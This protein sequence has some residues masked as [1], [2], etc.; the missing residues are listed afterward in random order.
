[1]INLRFLSF[2]LCLAVVAPEML[3]AADDPALKPVATVNGEAIT[4]RQ[5]EDAMLA[6]EGV[7][8]L[9]QTITSIIEQ[10]D[11]TRLKDDDVVLAIAG[12]TITRRDVALALLRGGAGK[13]RQDLIQITIVNQALAKAGVTIG[14]DEADAEY[15]RMETRF[16]ADLK[17]KGQDLIDFASYLRTTEGKEP[18]AFKRDPGFLMLAGVHALVIKRAADE[19]TADDY[20][21]W[22]D[23]HR[24]QYDQQEALRLASIFIPYVPE[25]AKRDPQAE[26]N[27]LLSVMT[28][29]RER[30]VANDPGFAQTFEGFG[31]A[32]DSSAGKGGD[33][34]WVKRD[35]TRDTLGARPIPSVVMAEAWAQ[36]GPLPVLMR[37]IAHATGVE[38]T[39][40][41]AR[42]DFR[43]VTLNEV[44]ARVLD[45]M[46]A[47]QLDA[48]TKQMITELTAMALV[49]YKSLPEVIRAR[50]GGM[51]PLT[52]APTVTVAP[53]APPAPAKP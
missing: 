8:Q 42:R 33:L 46:L 3:T 20:Q 21:H 15:H 37:P 36:H 35:G 48:R 14:H 5:V 47:E 23:L 40:V 1:M 19:F 50:S 41:D 2:F 49:D 27:R 13:V 29:L 39:R 34:G 25:A 18:D 44:K 9:Q 22:F 10:T 32:Y 53:V 11:W 17:A 45:D 24:T 30:I 28:A 12:R 4:L 31:R 16:I 43:A 7:E 6:K 51:V 26:I 52:V 38:L